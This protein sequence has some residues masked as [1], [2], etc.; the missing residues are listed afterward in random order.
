MCVCVQNREG[1]FEGRVGTGFHISREITHPWPAQ[2]TKYSRMFPRIACTEDRQDW[3][4]EGPEDS[5]EEDQEA[6][7]GVPIKD[8]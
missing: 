7:Q 6:F 8:R 1:R 5:R 4:K 2:N 3:E